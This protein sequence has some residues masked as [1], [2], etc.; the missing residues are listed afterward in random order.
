MNF[1]QSYLILII[2]IKIKNNLLINMKIN[3]FIQA[4]LSSTRLPKKIFKVIQNKCILQHVIDRSSTSKLIDNIIVTTTNNKVDDEIEEYCIKNNIKYFRGSEDNVLSRFYNTSKKYESDI[5]IRITSDCPLIDSNIIDKMIL[6][7][8]SNNYSFLQP[9]YSNGDNQNCMAGFPDGCNPQ[10]FSI[11]LLKETYNNAV[12]DHDKEHVCPYMVR[13]HPLNKY[14]IEN[15]E[16]YKKIEFSKLHLS[17]DTIEDYEKIKKI[18]NNLYKSNKN[19]SIYDVL[20][21]LDS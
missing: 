3:L 19:F 8:K 21:Y 13:K 11:D 4:R 16:K 18:F 5:I 20:N 14:K 17:L 1:I 6:Y 7:F 2:K 12:T 10:I 15:L 9:E